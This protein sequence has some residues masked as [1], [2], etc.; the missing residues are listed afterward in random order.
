MMLKKWIAGLL[1]ACIAA[2]NVTAGASSL[3]AVNYFAASAEESVDA[4][5]ENTDDSTLGGE[6]QEGQTEDGITYI[7]NN[8]KVVVNGYVGESPELVIPEEINGLPVT[9][10]AEKA[11]EFSFDEKVSIEKVVIEAHIS[12]IPDGCFSRCPSLTELTMPD[13]RIYI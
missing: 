6:V 8:E 11:F 12:K 13:R 7:Y 1:S 5:N 2:G 10:I 3:A 4:A 9:D